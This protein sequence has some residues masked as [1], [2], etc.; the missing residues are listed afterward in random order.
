MSL[1]PNNIISLTNGL[2]N[3]QALAG[4]AG[5][6]AQV[7]KVY[8]CEHIMFVASDGN[9]YFKKSIEKA[10]AYSLVRTQLKHFLDDNGVALSDNYK[11]SRHWYYIDDGLMASLHSANKD[12]SGGR[13]ESESKIADEFLAIL[14]AAEEENVT[15][16]HVFCSPDPEAKIVFTTDKI[17]KPYRTYEFETLYAMISAFFANYLKHAD[18]DFQPSIMQ[19]ASGNNIPLT[20]GKKISFRYNHIPRHTPKPN[21]NFGSFKANIRLLRDGSSGLTVDTL[22]YLPA[23]L[24][25]VKRYRESRKGGFVLAGTT[26]SGKSTSNILLIDSSPKD[27]M[28][29]SIEDPVEA[30]SSHPMVSQIQ[31]NKEGAVTHKTVLDGLMRQ[32]PNLVSVGEI[33]NKGDLDGYAHLALTGHRV[34]ATTHAN[35]AIEIMQRFAKMGVDPAELAQEALFSVLGCQALLPKLCEHCRLSAT[36]S[37]AIQWLDNYYASLDSLAYFDAKNAIFKET[38]FL[39]GIYFRNPKGCSHCDPDGTQNEESKGIK[40]LALQAEFI[41]LENEDLRFIKNADY[42]GWKKHLMDHGWR[43]IDYHSLYNIYTGKICPVTAINN[44]ASVFKSEEE[45]RVYHYEFD[46]HESIA[47]EMSSNES[48]IKVNG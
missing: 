3:Q 31:I 34:H 40:G 39:S 29:Y 23:H 25:I 15:D 42:F 10:Q 17:N 43:S 2:P 44:S 6:Y 21:Q 24:Q 32:S 47:Q 18:G 8:D 5:F 38:K 37:K 22:G 27:F 20:N 36:D 9:I 26:N 35:S 46:D 30:I 7:D 28:S 16:L 14:E 41:K 4:M 48:L 45:K 1:D 33:R 11:Q 12:N 19:D 13:L